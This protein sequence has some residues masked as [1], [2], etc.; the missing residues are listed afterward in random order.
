MNRSLRIV[1]PR[2]GAEV[3]GGTES[4]VRAM[5]HALVKRGWQVSVWTSN[6]IEEST[7]KP[8]YSGL[9]HDD[10][11]VLVRRFPVQA[12]RN[13]ERFALFSRAFFRTPARARPE[14]TWLRMQGPY[15]PDLV[16]ALRDSNPVTTLFTPY[17]FYP[18]L[19]GIHMA[20]HPRILMP[21]AHDERPFALK[22][23][24]RAFDAADGLLFHTEEERDL[25]QRRHP[26]TLTLPS[27]VGS[28][29]VEK[30][31]CDNLDAV[32]GYRPYI[33]FGGR[34]TPGKGIE[35]LLEGLRLARQAQPDLRLIVSGAAADDP[36]FAGFENV[37]R[38]G[39]VDS[40]MRNQLLSGAIA[41][42]VPGALESLSM[43]ALE[44]WAAGRPCIL[45][46]D[47]AVLAGQAQRS[48]GAITFNSAR[49]LADAIIKLNADPGL[50]NNL[51]GAGQRHVLQTYQWDAVAERIE[52]L[53]PA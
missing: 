41:T 52:K 53:V 48:Q 29:G 34:T 5:A 12:T 49:T 24:A 47:S 44:S 13:P 45:N 39:I 30:I 46:G 16:N 28:V 36:S 2:Y 51:G 26:K 22:L 6:A 17:L 1:T 20:P 42:A 15:V 35:T 23:V 25:V 10:D 11:G 31:E 43:L 7:W 8:G 38:V 40:P 19:A 37:E 14:S 33:Y 18:T 27:A 3:I 50:A 9:Q 21:A 4:L 32:S